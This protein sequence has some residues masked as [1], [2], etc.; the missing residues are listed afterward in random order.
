MTIWQPRIARQPGPKYL[1]I[2]EALADDIAGGKLAPGARLPTHRRL[3]EQIGVTVGTITRAYAEAQRRGLI[4]GE[5]GRGSFVRRH[6]VSVPTASEEGAENVVDFSLNLPASGDSERRLAE[7]LNQIARGPLADLLDYGPSG[8]LP[9]HRA[10]GVEWLKRAGLDVD[11]E[12][13][14]VTNGAQHG[15]AVAF[16]A[17]AKPGDVILTEN[18]TFHGVK[19]LAAYLGIAL[20]GLPTDAEGVV[21]DAFDEAC[22]TRRPRALYC[23]PNLQNPTAV[24]MGKTRRQAIVQIA[25]RHD[26]RIVED[27]VY[28]FLLDDETQPPLAT[29][30]P[31]LTYY[32]TSLSKSIA[33]G[34]RLGYVLAPAGDTERTVSATRATCRMATPL[35]AEIAARWIAD[36]AAD[37]FVAYQ[38]REVAA[39]REIA[40]RALAGIPCP[41]HPKSFHLWIPLPEPWRA[42]TFVAELKAKGV[43]VLPAETFAVAPATAPHAVRACL[44]AVRGRAAVERGLDV[45]AATLRA[46]PRPSAAVV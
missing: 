39:R 38:R 20:V 2:A 35:M 7:T 22:R 26:V 37:A 18:L 46:G 23:M 14:S 41:T 30:A 29:L 11:R 10:A 17:I 21:P 5:I 40:A 33:P 45:L 31:E 32:V 6:D 44:G 34:L 42:G 36:G 13:V 15:M 16:M 28:G 3:A 1:A 27:D 9:R 24:V 4:S 19:E 25:R 43:L 8:G 12:R